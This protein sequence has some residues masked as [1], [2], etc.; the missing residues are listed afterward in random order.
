M[1]SPAKPLLAQHAIDFGALPLWGDLCDRLAD[2]FGDK[3]AFVNVDGAALSFDGYRQRVNRLNNALAARGVKKGDRVAILARNCTEYAETYGLAKSGYIV[4]PLNWRLTRDE[5][6]RLLEH[7]APAVVIADAHHVAAIDGLRPNLGSTHSFVAIGITAAGWLDYEALLA[8]AI[9][10]VPQPDAVLVPSDVICL[11]YTSGTT[12]QPKG[13]ALTHRGILANAR[14]SAQ[15]ILHLTPQDRTLAAMPMFHAGGM[16]YHFHGSYA[17]GCTTVIMSGFDA[18]RV[19]ETLAREAITNVHLVPTMISAL[20]ADPSI[21][22]VDLGA[23]RLI[24]YAAS[25]IPLDL[26][27]R[28]LAQFEGCDFIQ[29][30]GSTEAGMI[31]DLSAADHLRAIRE[32]KEQLLLSCGRP[33]PGNTV[34]IVD[35]NGG[36]RPACEIG[37]V[38][39][40]SPGRMARY[41]NDD[42]ATRAALVDSWFRSGDLGYQDEEGYLYLV[43]RKNDMIVTGGENV[44]PSEVEA[45]I[46][47]DPAVAMVS[48]FGVPDPV[49]VERVVAAVV[50][51]PGVQATPEQIIARGRTQ[52]AAYKCPKQVVVYQELPMN[53]AGKILK[54]E[55]KLAFGKQ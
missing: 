6:G 46:A 39:I 3:T 9:A 34:R 37:E 55:L 27:K 5:L 13:V 44:Y 45:V 30:Y 25:S 20:L 12:G 4:V 51:R 32:G 10:A 31:T 50:L 19:L 54:K 24:F 36:A 40:F 16:W 28:A 1:N 2:A 7:C 8:S 15:S 47:A 14:T 18:P 53:A 26:L 11:M 52:L 21:D 43:D 17:A 23:L 48:V 35:D 49:W 41:W 33:A 42:A 38:E 29:S 22:K